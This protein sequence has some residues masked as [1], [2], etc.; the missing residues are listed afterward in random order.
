MYRADYGGDGQILNPLTLSVVIPMY[1][2]ALE[3]LRALNTL[4]GT[5]SV[6]HEY[7]VQEDAAEYPV[8]IRLCFHPFQ[9]SVDVNPHNLGFA[10][11]CNAGAARASGDILLFVNQDV[12][13]V[14][15]NSEGWDLVITKPFAFDETVGI[16]G[17]R[18]LFPDS[19]IQSAGGLYDAKCQPFHRC[20]GYT[21]P[22]YY[23]VATPG[24]VSWVTGAALAIRRDLFEQVG[25]FDTGYVGGYFEDVSICESV[26]ALGY[27][28]WYE[29]SCTFI[30]EVGSTGGNPNFSAN[31]LRF[32]QQ[33]V[34]TGKVKPDEHVIRANYW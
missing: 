7:I 30:H 25:G 4:Q 17:A 11:N 19:S 26:K 8:D 16:V 27:K 9:A 21:D 31:A 3:T 34:D 33:W 20:L 14:K 22:N 24:E 2:G 29:P 10:G 28:V 1:R 5:A 18:L 23:E 32:K 13:A 12:I 6:A 15:P